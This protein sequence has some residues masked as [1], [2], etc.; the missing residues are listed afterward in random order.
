MTCRFHAS[1][2]GGD[3]AID[4]IESPVGCA[5]D[6]SSLPAASP[7]TMKSARTLSAAFSARIAPVSR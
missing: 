2:S 6:A 3:S 1:V 4:Q 5:S 7:F